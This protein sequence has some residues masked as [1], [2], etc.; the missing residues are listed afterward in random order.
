MIIYRRERRGRRENHGYQP[1][2]LRDLCAL[3]GEN[4]YFRDFLKREKS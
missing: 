3:C 2:N 1:E 4:S